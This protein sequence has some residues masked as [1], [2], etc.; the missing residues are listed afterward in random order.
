MGNQNSIN[1]SLKNRKPPPLHTQGPSWATADLLPDLSITGRR[2]S[3]PHTIPLRFSEHSG[4]EGMKV[5]ATCP[6]R[7]PPGKE[8]S[9]PQVSP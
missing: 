8:V 7:F 2:E 1:L 6:K 5:S 3:T 4:R 9:E